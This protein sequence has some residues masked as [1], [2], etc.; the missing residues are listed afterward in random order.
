MFGQHYITSYV[1]TDLPVIFS[2]FI[3][4]TRLGH[5]SKRTEYLSGTVRVHV[6]IWKSFA[7]GYLYATVG[8][9]SDPPPP[10]GPFIIYACSA[11]RLFCSTTYFFFAVSIVCNVSFIV[12]V[13]L[14]AVFCLSVVCHVYLC[15]M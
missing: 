9:L 10:P 5:Y 3:L 14:G 15:L 13:A 4:T 6:I 2:H 12:C 8:H 11:D 7:V 1:S